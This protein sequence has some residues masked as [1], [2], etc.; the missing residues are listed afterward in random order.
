MNKNEEQQKVLHQFHAQKGG[1]FRGDITSGILVKIVKRY[2][3]KDVLDVGAGSGAL[4][5][6]LEK[7]GCRTK[8]IDIHPLSDAIQYGTITDLQFD[9]ESFGTVFCTDII[10]HLT[11]EQLKKGLS[12]IRRVLKQKGYLV[13]TTPYKE[14][15]RINSYI[16]PECGHVFHRRGH[17]QAFDEERI[18]DLLSHYGFTVKLMKVCVLHAMAKLPLG[19]YFNFLFKR[20]N[21]DFMCKTL[22]V[23]CEHK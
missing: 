9:N 18:K 6:L 20:M 16:C 23:V 4:I 10:E 17:L 21:Y 3:H 1:L 8:G 15:L 19:R 22:V 2:I 5:D 11:D 12:E 14:D 13:I 7:L